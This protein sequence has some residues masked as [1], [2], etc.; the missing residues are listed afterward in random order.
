MDGF[1]KSELENLGLQTTFQ[2]VLWLE[3]KHIIELHAGF[4]K[5]SGPDETTQERVTLEQ[6]A[7]VL[8]VQGEQLTSS[9]TD[10]GQQ[11]L[12]DPQLALVAET[13]LSDELR[14]Q[15]KS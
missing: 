3:T 10:L 13:E 8:G 1:G 12:D 6:T 5:D 14:T 4:I 11:H 2:E 15:N 9:L 7:G